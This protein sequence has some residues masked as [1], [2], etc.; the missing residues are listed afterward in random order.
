MIKKTGWQF[1]KFSFIGALNTMVHYLVFLLLFRGLQ[2]PMIASSAVGYTFGMLN[3]FVLNRGWT[4]QVSGN[5]WGGE[6]IK[7]IVVNAISLG[8]N[9]VLLQSFVG[10]TKL[11]PEVSQFFAIIGSLI[12]NFTGNKC[13]TFRKSAEVLS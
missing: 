1:I 4:F 9:L 3:S 8:V 12:V 6:L 5:K 7:F 2:F 13:W 10:I 11:L